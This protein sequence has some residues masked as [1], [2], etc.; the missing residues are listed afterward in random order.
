MELI[1]FEL[2]LYARSGALSALDIANKALKTYYETIQIQAKYIEALKSD[3]EELLNRL[4]PTREDIEQAD[5]DAVEIP[6]SELPFT[7]NGEKNHA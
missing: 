7:Q 3:R 5:R 6:D 4:Y 2:E 1:Q